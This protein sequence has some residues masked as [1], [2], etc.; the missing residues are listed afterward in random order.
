MDFFF[1][2]GVYTVAFFCFHDSKQNTEM[3]KQYQ[4]IL[5]VI[6]TILSD[7]KKCHLT[8][9]T[10]FLFLQAKVFVQITIFKHTVPHCPAY[11]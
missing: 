8:V 5:T 10:D 3:Y 4:N 11:L 9:F 2:G 6:Q 7:T 1:L